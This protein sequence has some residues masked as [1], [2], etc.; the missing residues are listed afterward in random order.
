[1]DRLTR[2]RVVLTAFSATIV[3]AVAASSGGQVS[4]E[5][6]PSAF[7]SLVG[8][9]FIAFHRSLGRWHSEI[10]RQR[11][12]R[13]PELLGLAHFGFGLTMFTAALVGFFLGA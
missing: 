8:G 5:L 2:A 7:L 13:A 10:T 4:H 12:E 6:W 9:V 1:M 11:N 3:L